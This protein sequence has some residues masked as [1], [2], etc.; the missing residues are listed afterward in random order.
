MLK[1]LLFSRQKVFIYH[2]DVH[3]LSQY[4]DHLHN[5]WLIKDKNSF[6]IPHT[7]YFYIYQ[8]NF[9]IF[10]K[11]T[12]SRTIIVCIYLTCCTGFTCWFSFWGSSLSLCFL[13]VS[14][15]WFIWGWCKC[16]S[17]QRSLGQFWKF[18]NPL[19]SQGMSPLKNLPGC[20]PKQIVWMYALI[21][22]RIFLRKMMPKCTTIK[23]TRYTSSIKPQSTFFNF[24]TL[25]L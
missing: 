8:L 22:K 5:E 24:S 6:T 21:K 19:K 11:N 12:T 15:C 10:I 25:M 13:S 1:L 2:T 7:L 23:K 4:C 20:S 17:G 9:I 14:M 3:L 16:L 18:L